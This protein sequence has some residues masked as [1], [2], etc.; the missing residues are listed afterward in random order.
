MLVAPRRG[1]QQG[2]VDIP[3]Q[4][5]L[6]W[7]VNASSL[8]RHGDDQA[9]G[10]AGG[11]RTGSAGAFTN[12]AKSSLSATSAKSWPPP[13]PPEPAAWFWMRM[14]SGQ[15]E[16]WVTFIFVFLE[17]FFVYAYKDS[18]AHWLGRRR[19]NILEDVHGSEGQSL[20]S[21]GEVRWR[22]AR[23]TRGG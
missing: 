10:S 22:G 23:A 17:L 21:Q 11:W 8:R 19:K 6:D 13:L 12:T 20:V 4:V 3:A 9:L 15:V 5:F 14:R 7:E 1:G 16:I 18:F 2:W